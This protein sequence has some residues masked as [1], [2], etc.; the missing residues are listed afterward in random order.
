M[1]TKAAVLL[2]F[3]CSSCL[4]YQSEAK[5]PRIPTKQF[6]EDMET[7]PILTYQCY[8]SGNSIDPP[9]SIN[10]TILWDGTDSST[11]NAIGTT[12]SAVAG[13]PNSYT[14]GS[15][16]THYDA[17]SGVGKLTTST[18]REDLTVVEPFFGKA[19]YLKIVLT[20]NNNEEVS[21]IYDV[22]YKCKNAKKLLAKVCPDPCAWELTRDV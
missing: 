14:R 12:W 13:T 22:D 3:F 20:S 8:H 17:A 2:M 19:L 4:I 9:G 18:V 5:T 15:L 21:K 16:S 10:Y 11:T 1:E 7:R 6:Y